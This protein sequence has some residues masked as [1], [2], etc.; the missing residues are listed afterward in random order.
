MKTAMEM[1]DK[2]RRAIEALEGARRDGVTH[3]G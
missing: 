2:Q 1:T 3:R